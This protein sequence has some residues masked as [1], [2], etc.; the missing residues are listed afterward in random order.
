MDPQ[1]RCPSWVRCVSGRPFAVGLGA[2]VLL[3]SAG[4]LFTGPA[5]AQPGKIPVQKRGVKAP[6][7]RPS[8]LRSSR[9]LSSSASRRLSVRAREVQRESATVRSGLRRSRRYSSGAPGTTKASAKARPPYRVPGA[10]EANK[11]INADSWPPNQ[12]FEGAPTRG[13][14]R[15][16]EVLQRY[17]GPSGTYLAPLGTAYQSVALPGG[18]QEKAKHYYRVVRPVSVT[19]GRIAP[20][21]GEPGGGMQFITSQPVSELLKN[22][23]LERWPPDPAPL[24]QP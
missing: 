3:L 12:G 19:Q 11:P 8:S 15:A 17:G 22:G 10:N 14:L 4:P 1:N 16:G 13:T 6:A 23:S 21:F 5:Y 9:S 20:A 24:R 2:I 18:S 7:A